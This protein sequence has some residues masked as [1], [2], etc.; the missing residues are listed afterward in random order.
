M[1]FINIGFKGTANAD[2]I[3][4]VLPLNDE[5][6]DVLMNDAKKVNKFID[7]TAG[8]KGACLLVMDD[9][10]VVLLGISSDTIFNR[11]TGQIKGSA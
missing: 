1:N 9:N 2:K 4:A 11:L 7:A 6:A 5:V 8:H 10:Y 3:I